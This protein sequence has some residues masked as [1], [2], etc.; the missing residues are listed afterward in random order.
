MEKESEREKKK[1]FSLKENMQYCIK[2][3]EGGR[4]KKNA[5]H[6]SA[7]LRK[8]EKRKASWEKEREKRERKQERNRRQGGRSVVRKRKK[9]KKPTPT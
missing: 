8:N 4:G 9:K 3:S 7:V 5:L 6:N 2:S 1:R